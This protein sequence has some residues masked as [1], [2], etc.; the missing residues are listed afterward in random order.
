M[1]ATTF[2]LLKVIVAGAINWWN[3]IS[4]IFKGKISSLIQVLA[5]W[6]WAN[7]LHYSS[8]GI[9]NSWI[10]TFKNNTDQQKPWKVCTSKISMHMVV[11][12][13]DVTIVVAYNVLWHKSHDK[14]WHSMFYVMT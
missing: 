6:R 7:L 14:I 5:I 4:G 8:L 9:Q 2:H 11:F 3:T 1:V 12:N 10:W 13:R